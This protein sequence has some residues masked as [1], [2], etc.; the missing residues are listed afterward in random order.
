[1]GLSGDALDTKTAQRYFGGRRVR[2]SSR[3]EVLTGV[4]NALVQLGLMPAV[5]T[6]SE[7][8]VS[9][10]SVQLAESALRWHV[11][12]WD[13]VRSHLRPRMARVQP[14]H[15][16]LVARAFLRLGAIDIALRLAAGMHVAG[17]SPEALQVIDELDRT[18]RGRP[19][20]RRRA[21][22][23]IPLEEL[24]E[25][26]GVWDQ[27]VDAW[28]Y[29]GA[30][31]SD[32]NLVAL[33]ESLSPE[34]D[35]PGQVCLLSYLRR[36]YWAS[37]LV[38]FLAQ[39]LDSGVPEEILMRL[40]AYAGML[41]GLIDGAGTGEAAREAIADLAHYGSGAPMAG[42][43]LPELLA[44]EED[45]E[46]RDD[47]VAAGGDWTARVLSV[48]YGIDQEEVAAIDRATDGDLLRSWDVASPEAYRH[49]QRSME[50]Q[51]EGRTHEAL[52]EVAKAIELDPLD[53]ANHFTMGSMLGGIGNRQRDSE[54]VKRGLEE[55]RLASALD[56]K[57][58]L[59]WTEIGYILVGAGRPSDALA[60]LLSIPKDC[61]LPD[62]RY[63]MALGLAYQALGNHT[64]SL[65]SFERALRIDPEDLSL[66]VGAGIAAVLHGDRAKVT[67][68]VKQ[69]RQL[70]AAEVTSEDLVHTGL[71]VS[72][73][74]RN[75]GPS[76]L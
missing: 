7:S 66:V 3:S 64:D 51:Y 58:I 62:A 73:Q 75:P 46:W 69:A 74:V 13:R 72:E 47:L 53:P 33:S 52:R 37:D 18:R 40:R 22:A 4:A 60:H 34:D 68:Y 70:G 17:V 32:R 9:V 16:G 29:D 36:F 49:F 41:F 67:R 30:R 57:W 44:R 35:H 31:P 59:P 19:L 11:T 39:S 21:A 8:D 38:E 48:V 20:N 76:L 14:E 25:R 2:D 24:A 55:C 23:R 43:L 12:T 15:L 50:L 45:G 63:Q 54:M 61:G 1:M 28:M 71:L 10:V 27:T 65:A 5:P 6:T 56:P 42:A 26:I